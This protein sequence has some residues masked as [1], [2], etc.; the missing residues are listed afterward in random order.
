MLSGEVECDLAASTGVHD[1]EGFIKQILVGATVVQL[2][3]VL[4]KNGVEHIQTVLSGLQDWMKSHSYERIDDFR[5]MLNRSNI[6]DPQVYERSQY[7][8]ALV[9]IW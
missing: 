7:V 8:K 9:G 3:S 1:A 6:E 4:L 5:G 2:C